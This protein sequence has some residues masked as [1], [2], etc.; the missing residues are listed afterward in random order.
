MEE[1]NPAS[2]KN[3]IVLFVNKEREPLFSK[4]KQKVIV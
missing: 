4:K 3:L 1:N 2:E